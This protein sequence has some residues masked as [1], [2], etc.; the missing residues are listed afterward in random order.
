MRFVAT[1]VVVAVACLVMAHYAQSCNPRP[2]EAK[3]A[4]L[5]SQYPLFKRALVKHFGRAWKEAAVVSYREGSWHRNASNGQYQGTFQMGSS[6]RA[7]YGHGPTLADQAAAAARY[8]RRSGWG[9]WECKP[10]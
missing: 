10:Y 8:W 7:K 2:S 3:I 9:P 1:I 5:D 4:S 6:E